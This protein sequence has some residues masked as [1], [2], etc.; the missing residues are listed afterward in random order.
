MKKISIL[1]PL[2]LL[3]LFAF[4]KTNSTSTE[5]EKTNSKTEEDNQKITKEEVI[6]TDD[7]TTL[8]RYLFYPEDSK[9]KKS[10]VIVVH[11][12]CTGI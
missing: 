11:E 7:E 8:N 10:G 4:T 3:A 12:W 1:I 9:G 2:I 5:S 6:Y